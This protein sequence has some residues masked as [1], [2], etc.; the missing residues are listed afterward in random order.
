[1]EVGKPMKWYVLYK[2]VGFDGE[3]K[4]GPYSGDQF[5]S[6]VDDI[7]SYAGVYDVRSSEAVNDDGSPIVA[8]D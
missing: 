6:Q 8:G 2:V 3:R 5:Q 1:M 4:A 7:S